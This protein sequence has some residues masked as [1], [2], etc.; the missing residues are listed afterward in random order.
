MLVSVAPSRRFIVF[1][2]LYWL[3]LAV[4]TFWGALW[5]VGLVTGD[6]SAVENRKTIPWLAPSVAAVLIFGSLTRK[7]RE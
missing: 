4:I 7:P 5:L 2:T 1:R 6:M 3:G